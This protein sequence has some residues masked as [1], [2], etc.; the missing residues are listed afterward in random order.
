MSRE[1]RKEHD[2]SIGEITF[3]SSLTDLKV[4]NSDGF[5]I[6]LPQPN[7]LDAVQSWLN[8]G[9]PEVKDM[10]SGRFGTKNK[11][12]SSCGVIATSETNS[13]VL[14][15]NTIE[16]STENLSLEPQYLRFRSRATFLSIAPDIKS[17]T[18]SSDL[19][20]YR[21]TQEKTW[22]G[23]MFLSPECARNY[24]ILTHRCEFVELTFFHAYPRNFGFVLKD[25]PVSS[26]EY[27]FDEAIYEQAILEYNNENKKRKGARPRKRRRD[28]GDSYEEVW[29][30]EGRDGSEWIYKNV[31]PPE[32]DLS[33]VMWIERFR[34]VCYRIAIGLVYRKALEGNWNP[35]ENFCFG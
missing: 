2:V 1:D 7:S 29:V 33:H 18:P 31:G 13:A 17:S 19:I 23:T 11:T 4:P 22:V 6:L 32:M 27:I 16:F 28:S 15:P 3:D 30:Y 5:E 25:L 10:Y 20:K 26:R 21:I 9:D 24:P 12:E 8:T 34:G 14:S 35:E